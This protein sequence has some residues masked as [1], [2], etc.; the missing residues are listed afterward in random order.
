MQSADNRRTPKAVQ[1][2]LDGREKKLRMDLMIC[3]R[4]SVMLMQQ[5]YA[6]AHKSW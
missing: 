5:L 1:F 2:R 6:C 3:R 4:A